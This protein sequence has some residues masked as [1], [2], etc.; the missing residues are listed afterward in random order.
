RAAQ[1]SYFVGCSAGGRQGMIAAQRYPDD[2]DGII[3]GSPGLN[4]S[5][6]AL[7]TVWVG[8][9]VAATPLP[10]E[11][12][13]ALNAAA[14]AACDGLDGVEDG[15]IENPRQCSFDPAVLQC[16]GAETASCLTSAQ[17]ET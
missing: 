5:G 7:Q 15:L 6:R 14:I 12:F 9:A 16:S 2:Y 1:R 10:A 4:W 8:Q 3:A 17:V 13:P 11:K